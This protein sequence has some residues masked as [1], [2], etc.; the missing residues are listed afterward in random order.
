LA[1]GVANFRSRRSRLYTSE[2]VSGAYAEFNRCGSSGHSSTPENISFRKGPQSTFLMQTAYRALFSAGEGTHWR[3]VLIHGA[4]GGVG[5]ASVQ[6]AKA[7][8]LQIIGTADRMKA[9]C[10]PE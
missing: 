7:A 1:E 6:W 5:L 9:A 4:S 2:T 3:D 8:G 10:G